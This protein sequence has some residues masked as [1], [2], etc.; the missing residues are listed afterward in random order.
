MRVELNPFFTNAHGKLDPTHNDQDQVYTLNGRTFS[1]KV[2][3][4]RD[5][6]KKPYSSKEKAHQN[7]FKEA[8]KSASETLADVDMR[9]AAQARFKAQTKYKSLRGFLVAEYMKNN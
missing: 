7:K 6:S 5:I 2:C 1:R 8:C 4:P 3:N 9:A